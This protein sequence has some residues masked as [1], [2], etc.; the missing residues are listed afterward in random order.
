MK[1]FPFIY[2][3]FSL[4]LQAQNF[5]IDNKNAIT[6]NCPDEHLFYL[7][8]PQ[9]YPDTTISFKN[10]LHINKKKYPFQDSMSLCKQKNS[11][12]APAL[13]VVESS[14]VLWT[15]DRYILKETTSHIGID[16]WKH[17][18]KYGWQWGK[19]N[20][21]QSF[22]FN[23]TSGAGYFN[24]ARPLGFSFYESIPFTIG[25]SVLLEYFGHTMRPTYNDIIYTPV[26]GIFFGEILYRLSSDVLD[27]RT[28]GTERVFR[29]IVGGILD[30]GRAVT[31]FMQGKTFKVVKKDD[32][33]KEPLNF[34]ISTGTDRINNGT[35]LETGE[36]K[37]ML[38]VNL[39]YGN[40]FEIK[41]RE[42]LDYF[43]LRISVTDK[44]GEKWLTNVSEYGLLHGWNN[45]LGKKEILSG[46]FQY[47]DFLENP[48]YDL[49]TMAFGGGFISRSPI[50]KN[51]NFFMNFHLGIIPFGGNSK[52]FGIDTVQFRDY[53]FGGG[54]ES[55]LDCALEFSKLVKAE[56]ESNYYWMY[57]Y[58]SIERNYLTGI[59][60]PRLIFR[61]LKNAEFGLE[62]LI[63]Y[64]NNFADGISSIHSKNSEEKIFLA[65]QLN[66][67]EKK[68]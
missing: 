43:K 27:E 28:S 41:D 26:N 19:V 35:E 12:W 38:S 47:Y 61:F 46:I 22:F 17:N 9:H 29:E 53:T 56:I 57:S 15:F 5:N 33:E 58:N 36:I 31:R 14:V 50:N 40:P 23:M 45:E 13:S 52:K 48:I 20:F 8:K 10:S 18:L 2:F 16:S 63:Y 34:A 51:T 65:Y 37:E 7:Q 3:I 55:K 11:I 42:I 67:C 44:S 49:S 59:I 30:P 24:S 64:N 6:M 39:V 66:Y 32:Y 60:N 54:L 68:Q 62:Y 4:L 25:G 21:G 1:Y